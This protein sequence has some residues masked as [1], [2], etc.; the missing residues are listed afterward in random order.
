MILWVVELIISFCCCCVMFVILL[1]LIQPQSEN[2]EINSDGDNAMK[3]RNCCIVL[4]SVHD[5]A[6]IDGVGH[7]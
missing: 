5:K 7:F 2:D 1:D 4:A 3:V 6:T